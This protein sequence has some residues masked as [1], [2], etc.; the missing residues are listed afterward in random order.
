[1]MAIEPITRKE[2]FLA[3]AGG[4]SVEELKPIT[5]EE[6]FL[7]KIVGGGSGGGVQ[8]DW[9]QNDPTAADYVKNRTHWV[10]GSEERSFEVAAMSP[11]ALAEISA[12]SVGD[13]VTVKVDGTEYS[14]VAFD[15]DGYITIGDTYV[16]LENGSG[17]YGWQIYIDESKVHFYGFADHTVSFE[18]EK[19]HKCDAKF[20]PEATE[21]TKGAV[22]FGFGET[23]AART[24][25]FRFDAT[26]DDIEHFK[27]LNSNS[28]V[29][30]QIV[31]ALASYAGGAMDWESGMRFKIL[32]PEPS[33]VIAKVDENGNFTMDRAYDTLNVVRSPS[34]K[35]FEITVDDNGSLSTRE[36]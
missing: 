1:M 18:C 32:Q 27:T 30:L 11:T 14:L 6:M 5:R 31:E 22:T 2:K 23:N 28:G 26:K 12:F 4:Q 16:D 7:S 35:Y 19:V 33:L 8:P 9:N 21:T 29:V 24:V 17:Q 10:E 20:L 15:D 34:G 13:T 36:R 25:R 3:K